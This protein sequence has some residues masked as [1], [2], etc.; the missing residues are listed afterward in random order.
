MNGNQRIEA[1]SAEQN[2]DLLE[3]TITAHMSKQTVSSEVRHTPVVL[4][5][6]TGE[7]RAVSFRRFERVALCTESTATRMFEQARRAYPGAKVSL[8]FA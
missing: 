4:R 8:A 3:V 2:I 5:D 6:E 7:E 1:A